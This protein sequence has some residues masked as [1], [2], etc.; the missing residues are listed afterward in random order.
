M[1]ILIIILLSL[2]SSFLLADEVE[3]TLSSPIINAVNTEDYE[4]TIQEGISVTNNCNKMVLGHTFCAF[5]GEMLTVKYPLS[6]TSV[7]Q[8][9]F[10][11]I[12][13]V[14]FENG[15]TEFFHSVKL[16][17]NNMEVDAIT[18]FHTSEIKSYEI[19]IKIKYKGD[20][21]FLTPSG[22]INFLLTAN[23]IWH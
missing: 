14:S 19:E 1:R 18:E 15:Q 7:I 21:S 12:L 8:S 10:Y 5:D 23:T 2:Y 22:A 20:N 13:A 4:I 11:G 6:I 9:G 17:E 16:L 3:L